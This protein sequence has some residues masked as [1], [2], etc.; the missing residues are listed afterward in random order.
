VLIVENPYYRAVLGPADE[1]N[2]PEHGQQ[3]VNVGA[4]NLASVPDTGGEVAEMRRAR[5]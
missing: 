5:R 2:L 4:T 3:K 1:A